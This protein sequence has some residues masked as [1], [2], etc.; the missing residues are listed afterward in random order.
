[1]NLRY[2][3]A[4]FL[5]LFLSGI[6]YADGFVVVHNTPRPFPLQVIYHHVT[7]EIND[8]IAKTRIE[9]VFYN[10]SRIRAE[11]TYMFPIPPGAAISGFTM[12]IDGKVLSGEILESNKARMIYNDIVRRQ[13]DPALLEYVDHGLYKTSVFPINPGEEK[14]ITIEYVETL[15]S[16]FNTFQYFYPLSTEKFSSS[17]IKDTRVKISI[18]DKNAIKTVFSTTHDVSVHKKS[19]NH[20]D[21]SYEES[22]TRPDRDLILY[23]STD[24]GDVGISLATYRGVDN[25]DGFFMLEI[26]PGMDDDSGEAIVKDVAFII[27]TSGS[28]AGDKIIKA[29]QAL[30]FCIDNLNKNDRFN[31][32]RFS[33]EAEG[34]F[35][36]FERT[37]E[38][39][40]SKALNFIE[41]MKPIGGT[42]IEESLSMGLDLIEQDDRLKIVI[43]ITDGKP[44]IG[45]MDENSLIDIIKR[46]NINN[47]RIFTFGIGY[48]INTHLLDKITEISNGYRSY[49]TPEEDIEIKISNF[50][51]KMQNPVFANLAIEMNGNVK[52][53]KMYPARL[54]DLFSGS[55]VV[56]FGRYNGY[57]DARLLLRG[58]YRNRTKT[59]EFKAKFPEI[60]IKDKYISLLWANRRVGFL[61]DN[62]RLN[63]ESEELIEEIIYL[64]RKYG[65]ITPYTSYLILEDELENIRTDRIHREQMLVPDATADMLNYSYDEYNYSEI[66]KKDGKEAVMSSRSI[67]EMSDSYNISQQKNQYDKQ[68]YFDE[69]VFISGRTFYKSGKFWIDSSIS[70]KNKT[71]I[72][73][74]EFGSKAYMKLLDL[75]EEIV[76]ILSLGRNIRFLYKGYICE[77]YEKTDND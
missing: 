66:R 26:S 24:P 23:Y 41:N 39:E 9:Q 7:A 22:N 30:R 37:G 47:T 38:S 40:I 36:G 4:F 55:S 29:K 68:S 8:N 16:D 60:S 1:M 27:D 49:V 18:R 50:F 32:I 3:S 76:R 57:G 62:I 72:R 31:I 61:L 20:V 10:P 59:F 73:R 54:P 74:V 56:I 46:S 5:V 28:M 65:I 48:D 75:D 63:G 2:W 6:L 34:L 12:D 13:L 58:N 11:G 15:E 53:S 42:N 33:T 21:I 52:L 77:I 51:Q 64:S 43:F 69:T 35:N 45:E 44:T 71:D 25:E 14:R 19:K 67:Q 70:E 17:I